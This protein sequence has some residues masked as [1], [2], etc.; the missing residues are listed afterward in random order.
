M[1][2]IKIELLPWGTKPSFETWEMNI[3]NDASGTKQIGNYRFKIFKK[4]SSETVWKGG[5]IKNFKRLQWSMW[6][7]L[8]LCLHNIYG[9][10]NE[11]N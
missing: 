6:Y 9:G 10:Q 5:E 8:Y 4:N 2:R 3:W 11:R 1:L 7:L